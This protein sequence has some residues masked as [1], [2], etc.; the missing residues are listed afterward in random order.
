MLAFYNRPAS[1]EDLVDHVVARVLD[2]LGVAH[3]LQPP[4]PEGRN[5]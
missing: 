4:W 5:G 3:D 2:Q 1:V